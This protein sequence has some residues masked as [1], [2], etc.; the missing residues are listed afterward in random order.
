MKY[1]ELWRQ[2]FDKNLWQ[3]KRFSARRLIKK[4]RNK[5]EKM[6][7]GQLLAKA[8]HNLSLPKPRSKWSAT[9]ILNCITLPQIKT[10]LRWSCKFLTVP[11]NVHSWFQQCKKCKKSRKSISAIYTMH[12]LKALRHGSHSFTC[13]IH[14]AYLSFVSI[15]QMV[16]PLTEV[17]DIRLQLTTHL[18]IVKG[19]KAELA[20]KYRNQFKTQ[21]HIFIAHSVY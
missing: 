21:W 11:Y 14:H 4:F 17:A 19:W 2:N 15:Y 6:N 7:T 1:A 5:I 8:A 13:K 18:L 9:V 3:S 12:G 20:W 10:Q 16:P